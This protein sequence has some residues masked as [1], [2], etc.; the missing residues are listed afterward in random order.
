MSVK[1][2]HCPTCMNQQDHTYTPGYGWV[3]TNCKFMNPNLRFGPSIERIAE[4]HV[5]EKIQTSEDQS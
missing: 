1:W 3:C 4:K 5:K 2:T